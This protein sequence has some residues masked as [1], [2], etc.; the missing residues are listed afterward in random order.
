MH[1]LIIDDDD[2]TRDAL[3]AVM[4][5]EGNAVST[6]MNGLEG[7]HLLAQGPRPDVVLLDMMM[8]V[9]SGWEF[10]QAVRSAPALADLSVI[11]VSAAGDALLEATGA[12]AILRKPLSFELLFR[13][14]RDLAPAEIA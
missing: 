9:M 13:I 4:E 6:A 12:R 1:I 11:I 14:L 3:S 7:L 10:L 2:A 8:P 5:C